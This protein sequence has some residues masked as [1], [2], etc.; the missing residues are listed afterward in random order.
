MEQH[1]HNVNIITKKP[2]YMICMLCV[3]FILCM[4]SAFIYITVVK[5]AYRYI[6]VQKNKSQSEEYIIH[7]I[8]GI[9]ATHYRDAHANITR[10]THLHRVRMEEGRNSIPDHRRQ[11]RLLALYR[12]RQ[13]RQ[14]LLI[15]Q[16]TRGRQIGGLLAQTDKTNTLHR[17]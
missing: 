1:K 10:N 7:N 6:C 2:S 17:F 11:C 8:R 14:Q 9:Y 16:Y 12:S 3:V 13:R 4:Y 15:A 5:T